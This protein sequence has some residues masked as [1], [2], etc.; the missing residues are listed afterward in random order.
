MDSEFI[1]PTREEKAAPRLVVF[2]RWSQ[3]SP[4]KW[5]QYSHAAPIDYDPIN[6][7][8]GSIDL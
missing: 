6:S 2:F 7:G 8:H 4:G 1:F 5:S 3:S